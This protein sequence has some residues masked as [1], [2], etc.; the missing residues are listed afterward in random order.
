M[1]TEKL[2]PI[3]TKGDLIVGDNTGDAARL[4]VGPT[5]YA[6][7]ADPSAT[8]GMTWGIASGGAT[9]ATGPTGPQGSQGSI[10]PQ[11]TQGTQGSQGSAGSSTLPINSSTAA[12]YT[13]QSTD[14]GKVVSL[15]YTGVITAH[16]PNPLGDSG[17]QIVVRNGA[18]G[19]ITIDGATGV[20]IDAASQTLNSQWSEYVLIQETATN[21]WWIAS[22]PKGATGAT[23][24]QGTQGS[25]GVT[26]AQGTQGTQGSL[27][28][29]GAQGTQGSQGTI[30]VQGPQGTQGSL[31][32]TGA[33]GTQGTQGTI[34]V[35][36][37]QGTQGSQGSA[38]TNDLISPFVTSLAT[39][40]SPAP[41][42]QTDNV[43]KLTKQDQTANFKITGGT[44]NDGQLMY[45][46]I[47]ATSGSTTN[48]TW[49][50]A[51]FGYTA[52]FLQEG[53]AS[54]Q[55]TLPLTTSKGKTLMCLFQY[56]SANAFNR[57]RLIEKK[58]PF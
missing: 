3:T 40:G 16:I 31:G 22:A 52:S 19:T 25:I 53:T 12:S 57:W 46:Y 51:T 36:G 54:G 18:G 50:D 29:T 21:T 34:G 6:L 5:G 9:G 10:G 33:Q 15:N 13:F 44:A 48:I 8:Y 2:T 32:P 28:P 45:I 27:G 4:P 49:P 30:G 26:G 24:P 7:L 23:G 35:A 14:I 17:D 42:A 47:G 37:P 58:I 43:Y 41:N 1:A 11:G 55:L 20:T 39:A 56:D 38:G